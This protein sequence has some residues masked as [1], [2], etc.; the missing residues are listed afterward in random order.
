MTKKKWL[1]AIGFVL[2]VVL[3]FGGYYVYSMYSFARTIN[4]NKM[5]SF[6]NQPLN[7]A[8]WEGTEPVNIMIMGVD[9]RSTTDRPRSDTILLLSMNPTTK[10]VT[11]FSVMRD[12]YVQIPGYDKAKINAAFADGG[13]ELE[14]NT[15]SQYL[16][17][18]IH[19]YVATDFEGF[20]KIIDALGGIDVNVPY[21]MVHPDDG[22]YDIN[23][24]KGYQ[25]LDGHHALMYVRFRGTPRAD[26]DRTARQRQMM[27]LVTSKLKQP[28]NL[29]KLPSLLKEME[30]YTQVSSNMTP[31]AMTKL[32]SLAMECKNSSIDSEQLPPDQD[33]QETW[34]DLGE[35]VLVP[36]IPA[37]R[38]FVQEKIGDQTVA[39]TSVPNGGNGQSSSSQGQGGQNQQ[40]QSGQASGPTAV[41]NGPSVN[42]RQKPGTQYAIIGQVDQGGVVTIVEQ[43]GDWDYIKTA[44]GMYGYILGSLLTPQ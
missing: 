16:N 19:Y 22:I 8:K 26:F 10:K 31:D 44:D 30:P 2:V 29:I 39:P 34:D 5:F 1:R 4:N 38:K 11:L 23:L 24:K 20:A 7:A 27:Q 12:T 36:D 9:R 33:L 13:P 35:Q 28:A 21:D 37:V 40:G 18:P 32:L 6:G 42:V 25:H 15:V 43:D 41:V 17:I 14:M 3:L